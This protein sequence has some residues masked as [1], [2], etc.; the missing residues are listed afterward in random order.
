M[1]F[2]L[3]NRSLI[4]NKSKLYKKSDIFKNRNVNHISHYSSPIIGYPTAED[5]KEFNVLSHIWTTGD[6][7][8]KLANRYYGDPEY[9]W[10]LSWFNRKPLESDFKI[11]DVIH[12]PL[13]LEHVVSFFDASMSPSGY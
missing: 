7:L 1:A 8:Y 4:I 13:P 10:V 3:E 11:G 12:I 5:M 9:W 2:R 6:R